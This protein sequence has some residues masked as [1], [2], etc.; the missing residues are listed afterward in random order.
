MT[1]PV[2]PAPSAGPS[3]QAPQMPENPQTPQMPPVSAQPQTPQM[4]AGPQVSAVPRRARSLRARLLWWLIPAMLGLQ[5]AY[6]IMAYV[7]GLHSANLAYDRTL[8]VSARSIADS[9]VLTSAG[10]RV[11]SP[12][13]A[14]DSYEAGLDATMYYRVTGLDGE[15]VSGYK[16]LPRFDASR[17]RSDL[18]P[19]LVSF[20]DGVYRG[21]A[22]RI[23]AL[24]QAVIDRDGVRSGM[25]LIEVAETM[26]SRRALT[27][28]ILREVL[29]GQLVQ[30]LL[31]GLVIYFFTRRALAPLNALGDEMNRREPGDT[32]P[33]PT[34]AVPAEAMPMVVALN[35][36]IERF[37]GMLATQRR[38]IADAAHQ[39]RTPIA[40]LRTQ[41]Q[42]AA[43]EEDADVVRGIAREM[44][45]S[46]GRMAALGEKLI[47]SARVAHGAVGALADCDLGEMVREVC[48]E[49]S[50]TARAHGIDLGFEGEEHAVV[51]GNELLRELVANLVD[52]ALRYT[53]RGGAVTARVRR[54]GA[55]V[56]LEVEDNGPGI[57]AAERAAVMEPFYRGS[58]GKG[59]AGS[60]LGL[61]IVRDV[62][63]QHGAGV[64]LLEA[65]GGGLLVRVGFESAGKG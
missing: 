17:P 55:R 14:L 9:L 25:A 51:R 8:L 16:D 30:M 1:D 21:Q 12:Y 38:F 6:G 46:S 7:R 47:S 57:P 2:P 27:R 33:L 52:N 56:W 22:V 10:L 32:T 15:F 34:G 37:R 24:R 53:P 62:A 35:G 11:D 4:P 18:Y 31:V 58:G 64:E 41:A 20:Y 60:G 61:A 48:L 39:L 26:G 29:F 50:A 65:P 54:D 43:R 28:R 49:C 5:M 3:F 40:V 59:V 42:L 44:A 45:D 63:R 13:V 23:A 19:A 36:Y